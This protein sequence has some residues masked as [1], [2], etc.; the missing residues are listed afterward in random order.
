MVAVASAQGGALEYAHGVSALQTGNFENARTSCEA[1]AR[2]L[3][4]D[5]AQVQQLGRAELCVVDALVGLGRRARATLWIERAIRHLED[6]GR[7]I[8]RYLPDLERARAIA[9]ALGEHLA[10]VRARIQPAG[11]CPAA[12]SIDGIA[13]EGDACDGR[14]HLVDAGRVTVS[15]SAESFRSANATIDV[16]PHGAGEVA[17]TLEPDPGHARWIAVSLEEEGAVL[18]RE[19]ASVCVGPCETLLDASTLERG[20]YVIGDEEGFHTLTV[21]SQ[22]S[23]RMRIESV[24]NHAIHGGVALGISALSFALAAGGIGL[25]TTLDPESGTV[26]AL[27]IGG[28]AFIGVGISAAIFGFIV[29]LTPLDPTYYRLVQ[30]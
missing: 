13:I 7:T 4:S 23:R 24:E 20:Y 26:P 30:R 27:V 29:V 15:V 14:L 28:F 9:P 18:M 2:A 8:E 10:H 12:M 3:E 1:A 6:G 25:A 22:L 19:R 5:P 17:V 16:V 11:A 21:E